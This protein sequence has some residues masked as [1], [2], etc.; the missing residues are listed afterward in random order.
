MAGC[1][2]NNVLRLVL[3]GFGLGL[4]GLRLHVL[5]QRGVGVVDELLVRLGVGAGFL[6]RD[7]AGLRVV[8]GDDRALALEDGLLEQ[9]EVLA[10]L[11]DAGGHQHGVAPL[12]A[13]ARLHAEVEDDVL[14]HALHARAGAEHLLHRAPLLA[15]GGLLPVV[16]ALGLGIEPRI[17]LVRRAEALVDV[18]RLIDEVEHHL[19]LH[20]LAELVGVDVA[21]EDFEAGLLVLLQQRRAGEADEDGIGQERLHGPVQLAALGAVALVHED[22]QLAHRRAGLGL[23]LLDERS[24]SS[25]PFRP[26]LWTSEQSRRGLAW[27]SWRHQVAAAA[28]AV[29]GL[30]RLGEDA[31]DLLVQ[32]V[33]V[34]DDDHAGVGLVLQD[35]LGQQHHD[36][37]LAAAL[38]VPDDAALVGVHVLLRGLDAEILVHPRQLS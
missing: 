31:L 10:R 5:E 8:G 21:A 18:P 33:A 23:Q 22:E 16:Q 37:A 26:N 24:K 13:Q 6:Q 28:G 38:R 27:P 2:L 1:S 35:P 9:L 34:G 19:V 30:A 25:T 17:D 14:H 12:V 36:D 3:V 4:A 15:Q 11:V 29:D 20:R 32:L 7:V